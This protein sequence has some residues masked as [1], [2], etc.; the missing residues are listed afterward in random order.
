MIPLHEPLSR[1]YWDSE[2]GRGEFRIAYLDHLRDELAY[3]L[4]GEVHQ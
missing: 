2:F 3:L 1:I 4:L